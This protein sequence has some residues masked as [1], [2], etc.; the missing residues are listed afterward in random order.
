MRFTTELVSGDVVEKTVST[1]LTL[2][3]INSATAHQS[4]GVSGFAQS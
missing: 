3:G 2:V 4:V 1:C